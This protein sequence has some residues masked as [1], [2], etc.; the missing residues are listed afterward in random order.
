MNNVIIK[1]IK[2]FCFVFVVLLG[3]N[4]SIYSMQKHKTESKTAS[5]G[6]SKKE[7]KKAERIGFFYPNAPYFEFTNFYPYYDQKSP[8]GI[9]GWYAPKGK[10]VFFMIDGRRFPSTE[11]YFQ[12]SKFEDKEVQEAFLKQV[13]SNGDTPL[14]ALN[15]AGSLKGS[16]RKD[17]MD[18]IHRSWIAQYG[19]LEIVAE[20]I[21]WSDTHGNK[22]TKL[23][24]SLN[25]LVMY[26]AV[27]AKV[28]QDQKV[29]DALVS[30]DGKE[31]QE[32]SHKDYYWG[33]GA[34]GNGLNMLGRIL[35][36]VRTQFLDGKLPDLQDIIIPSSV[37]SGSKKDDK[38]AM[39]TGKKGIKRTR[40]LDEQE[41][42]EDDQDETEETDG[43]AKKQAHK[44][45]KRSKKGPGEP[46]KHA[47]KKSKKNKLID[48]KTNSVK[49]RDFFRY[50][51]KNGLDQD[52]FVQLKKAGGITDWPS[53]F[54]HGTFTTHSIQEL[55]DATDGKKLTAL[56][57]DFKDDAEF[58]IV[59]YDAENCYE[60]RYLVDIGAMQAMPENKD[61]V[62]PLASNFHCLEGGQSRDKHNLI[63]FK[64]SGAVQ[65]EEGA[66]SGTP[67]AIW[68]MEYV[69]QDEANLLGDAK[70]AGIITVNDTGRPKIKCNNLNQDDI[71]MVIAR[72]RIGFHEKLQV[73]TGLSNIFYMNKNLAK[74]LGGREQNIHDSDAVAPDGQII[75]QVLAAAI[76]LSHG[77]L[78][79]QRDVQTLLSRALQRVAWEGTILSMPANN[80]QKGILTL[81]GCGAFGNR[82]A[83]CYEALTGQT[84]EK[85]QEPI[86]ELTDLRKFMKKAQLKLT[87]MAYRPFKADKQK[88]TEFN[89]F[90]SA[91][92]E[93]FVDN[94]GGMVYEI[95]PDNKKLFEDSDGPEELAKFFGNPKPPAHWNASNNSSNSNYGEEDAEQDSGDAGEDE[96]EEE[97]DG[98]QDGTNTQKDPED[99]GCSIM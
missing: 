79:G 76:D 61:A 14:Q 26:K 67:G 52:E 77:G 49:R 39:E 40:E 28:L 93:H 66:A 55:R 94:I 17:W 36:L 10:R 87:L 43:K 7:H 32:E 33:I 13:Q 73:S 78:G 58:N 54:A 21:D 25:D 5:K 65:G 82:F 29:Y 16:I 30:T 27:V 85:G 84:L 91:M 71:D 99:K 95:V 41:D 81:Y 22:Q 92:K 38:D 35:M 31:L 2:T 23:Y 74:G 70:L 24:I 96:E 34:Q 69:S 12:V 80:K 75:N 9:I 60:Y 62:F 11:H 88:N 98:G 83:W 1:S 89:D 53:D 8:T 90:I 68:R 50:V 57:K 86:A 97:G 46:V 15:I 45:I 72:G 4:S 6:K 18:R 47:G 19:L 63:V 48:E 51:M 56:T 37:E 3:Y 64:G 44:K 42:I 20:P 59:I